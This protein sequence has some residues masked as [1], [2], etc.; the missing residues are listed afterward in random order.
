MSWIDLSGRV[1]LVTGGS[2]GLGRTI[3]GALATAGADVAIASRTRSDLDS[4]AATLRESG[5]RIL[6]VPTLP[7][8]RSIIFGPTYLQQSMG[9]RRFT[10]MT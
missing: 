6:P 4:V 2:K 3:A 9:A 7:R 5:R 10:C 1:A 8:R